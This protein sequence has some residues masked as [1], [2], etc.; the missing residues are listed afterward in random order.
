VP[1]RAAKSDTT[2]NLHGVAEAASVVEDEMLSNGKAEIRVGDTALENRRV[3]VHV[4][5]PNQHD[6]QADDKRQRP[7][8]C[9]NV[10]EQRHIDHR[11]DSAE[12]HDRNDNKPERA[13][14]S[15][16]RAANC[17]PQQQQQQQRRRATAARGLQ[18]TS[19]AWA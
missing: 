11:S 18:C 3:R 8:H 16:S 7:K 12:D 17:Q 10:I 13:A 5:R 9:P 2:G 1:G 14:H 6:Q 15:G 19:E 4:E